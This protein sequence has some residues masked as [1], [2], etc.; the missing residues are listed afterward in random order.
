MAATASD[1]ERRSVHPVFDRMAG[2]GWRFLVLAAVLVGVLWVVAQ[3]WVVLLAVVVALYITRALEVPYRWMRARGAP[4]T[5]ASLTAVLGF[6]GALALIGWLLVPQ[7][8]EEFADLGP[9]LEA[10]IDDVE[11]WLIDDSPFDLNEEDLDDARADLASAAGRVVQ[12]SGGAIVGWAVVVVEVFTG[13]LLALVSAFFFLKDGPRM[14]AAGLRWFPEERRDLVARM[15]RRAWSTL[16]GYLK[17]VAMLGVLEGVIIGV[18]VWAVGGSLFWAVAVLTLLAAFV[19]IVGAVV[20]GVIAVL[21][22]LATAGFGPAVI[23]AIVA[24]VVQQLDNDLLAPVIYG[25]AL[26]LHPLVVLFSVVIGGALFGL[27]GTILA[28]PFTAVMVNMANEARLL[29]SV[30][31]DPDPEAALAPDPPP[32]G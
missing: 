3:L 29:P 18:A 8:S 21:V 13:L 14:Q 17:G 26:Q 28:V 20:A 23:V 27:G 22:T 31:A 5:L 15:G 1:D 9:T 24:V 25:K 12:A 2:Y 7:I 32:S 16:G 19:P 6:V 30:D 11:N 4:A 10:A